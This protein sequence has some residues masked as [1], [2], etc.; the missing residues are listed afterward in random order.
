LTTVRYPKNIWAGNQ[1]DNHLL[2]LNI[3]LKKKGTQASEDSISGIAN[4]CTVITNHGSFL[5]ISASNQILLNKKACNI[6]RP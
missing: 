4:R 3:D 5:H 1:P 6:E 2:N